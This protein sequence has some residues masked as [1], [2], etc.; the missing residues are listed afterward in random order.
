[1][2]KRTIFLIDEDDDSRPN[3]RNNLKKRGYHVS[4][5]IDEEDALDRVKYGC[6]EA[7]LIL[8]N[9]IRKP[10]EAVLEIGRNIRS[11]GKLNVPI[12]VIPHKY[13]ADLEGKDIKVG[14][15]DYISYLED[16]EQLDSLISFLMPNAF[17]DVIAA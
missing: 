17:D 4:I 5:A 16:G 12:V 13:G 3:F 7:D 8:M 9:F 2:N 11:V 14:E 6:F 1:M 15:R 10:P